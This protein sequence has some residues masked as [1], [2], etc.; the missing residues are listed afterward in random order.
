[1]NSNFIPRTTK[2]NGMCYATSNAETRSQADL[3]GVPITKVLLRWAARHFP[4]QQ[5]PKRSQLANVD[6]LLVFATGARGGVRYTLSARARY[7]NQ[8][9]G[10]L[11]DWRHYQAALLVRNVRNVGWAA[12]CSHGGGNFRRWMKARY[13]I[14]QGYGGPEIGVRKKVSKRIDFPTAHIP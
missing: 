8:S 7:T 2:R 13:G 1:M 11:N 6:D 12:E 4:I 5:G 3:S 14:S 9:T 10:A